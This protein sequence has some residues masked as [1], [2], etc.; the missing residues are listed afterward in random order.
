M[1]FDAQAIFANLAER[2]RIKGH[3]SV[4][5]R[6]IRVLSRALNGSSSGN[7]S[8]RD[9]LVL[10]DQALTDWLKARLKLSPWSSTSLADLLAKAV[11]VNLI[12]RRDAVRL[13]KIHH[14]RDR[15]DDAPLAV[16][17][18]QAQSALQFCI[19]LVEKHW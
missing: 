15:S 16:S 5:G 3:H 2:E 12:T 18:A 13:Q 6:A 7:L 17:A 9:V 1:S 14:T 10:C 4:E 8:A 11:K 19:E